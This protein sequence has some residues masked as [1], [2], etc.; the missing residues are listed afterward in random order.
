M[1]LVE[2]MII[3]KKFEH[4]MIK[5]Y[6]IKDLIQTV[7]NILKYKKMQEIIRVCLNKSFVFMIFEKFVKYLVSQNIS[8]SRAK[9]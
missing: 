1:K 8:K 9:L 3:Q 4:I 6:Y 5:Y 2:N 7:N